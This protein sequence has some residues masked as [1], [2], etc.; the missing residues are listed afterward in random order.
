MFA[1]EAKGRAWNTRWAGGIAGNKNQKQGRVFVYILGFNFTAHR[2]IR[3]MLDDAWPIEVD[4]EDGDGMNNRDWNL[5]ATDHAS[6]MKNAG[7]PI[8]NTSGVVG[9]ARD[10]RRGG[11]QAY[12]NANKKRIGL[13]RFDSFDEACA[14][15][16]RAEIDHGY[17]RNHGARSSWRAKKAQSP[18]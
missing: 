10:I 14:V 8:D 9:V 3:A 1:D 16:R 4:H 6:N 18:K 13:G 2:V 12:I 5:I 17:H 11:W 7:K 15:R